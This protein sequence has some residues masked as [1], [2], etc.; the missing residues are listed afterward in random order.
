MKQSYKFVLPVA[1]LA[2]SG[3]STTSHNYTSPSSANTDYQYVV[4]YKKIMAVE[5]A[6]TRS[7]NNMDVIWV[8][9]P[10]KKVKTKPK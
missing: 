4:D 8:N 2:V 7:S 3:C 10:M 1:L 9:T 5:R 6:T